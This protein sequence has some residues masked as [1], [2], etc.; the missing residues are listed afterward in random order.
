MET[1]EP[2]FSPSLFGVMGLYAV[3]GAGLLKTIHVDKNTRL[4][5]SPLDVAVKNMLYYAVKAAKIYETGP[6]ADIP[7]YMTSN[8]THF[9]LTLVEYIKLME[10]YHLWENGAYEKNLFIPGLHNT[11]NHFVYM[12]LVRYLLIYLYIVYFSIYFLF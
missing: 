5:I 11:S 4:D 3:T 12:F 9:N 10:E 7:V 2:G 6:P 8:C 1:P